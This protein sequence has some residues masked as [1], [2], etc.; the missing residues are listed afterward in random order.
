MK[1][2]LKELRKNKGLTQEQLSKMLGVKL[3]TY[4]TWERGSTN[5]SFPQAIACAEI[6]GCTLDELAGREQFSVPADPRQAAL[7][8]YYESMGEKGRSVLV[9]SA[10]LMSDGGSP[11]KREE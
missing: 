7:N 6:L 9:E 2:L 10:R 3:A 11:V 1:P 4:R 8:D 5:M